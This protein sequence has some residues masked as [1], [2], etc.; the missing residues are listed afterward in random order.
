MTMRKRLSTLLLAACAAAA[1]AVPVTADVPKDSA[2]D[3][4]QFHG[5]ARDNISK[6]TGLLKEWPKDG[7]PLAWKAKGI[8]EGHSSVAVANGKIFTAGSE[9]ATYVYALNESDGTQLW[10][11]R[12]GDNWK[13]DQG[14]DGPRSTP[15]V[16]GD[17]VYMI[18]PVGD[19]VCLKVGDANLRK[20]VGGN[21]P[22]WG[23][24]E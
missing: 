17:F 10:K 12:I 24:S 3:W 2:K 15:T 18:A 23:F 11:T 22:G 7:P 6:E 20:D 9:D 8:G 21:P 4:P 1:L 13:N 16:D 19:V 14:G 5:P